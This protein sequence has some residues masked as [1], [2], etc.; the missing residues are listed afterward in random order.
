VATVANVTNA[1]S[2]NHPFDIIVTADNEHTLNEHARAVVHDGDTYFSECVL[3]AWDI[4]YCID[5]NTARFAWADTTNGKGII[6]RLVDEFKND[7]PYDFKGIQFKAYGDTDDVWRYTFDDGED[8]N[9]K[10]YSLIGGMQRVYGNTIGA[11]MVDGRLTLNFIVFKGVGC[12]RNTIGNDCQYITFDI[13]CSDNVFS[14]ECTRN[15]F[16]EFCCGNKFGKGC[17]LNTFGSYCSSNTFGNDCLNNIFGV[18]TEAP[19]S[20]MRYITFED[21]VQYI[22]LSPTYTS[23]S[24]YYQNVTVSKGVKGTSENPKLIEDSNVNQSYKTTYQS[25]SSRVISL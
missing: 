3:A 23:T 19:M 18:Y 20:F 14:G 22:K 25:E 2:A 13:E 24:A 9:N 21:G 16:G 11:Y 5:N 10:D 7:C 4:W 6:Y 12:A 17:S 1:L 15:I 8:S